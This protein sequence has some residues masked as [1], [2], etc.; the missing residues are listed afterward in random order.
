M[1]VK[2]Q[3]LSILLVVCLL[4]ALGMNAYAADPTS[5]ITVTGAKVNATYT[6]YKIFDA[7]L[8]DD[9]KVAYTLPA[10]ETAESF[11]AN[12]GDGLKWIT[13]ADDGKTVTVTSEFADR[14]TLEKDPDFQNWIKSYAKPEYMVGEAKTATAETGTTLTWDNVPFGYYFVDSS[15]R[16]TAQPPTVMT[17]TSTDGATINEK[18]G[19]PTWDNSDNPP[20]EDDPN[21]GKVIIED[22]VKKTANDANLDEPI[23]FDIGVNTTNYDHANKIHHYIVEDVLAEGMTYITEPVLTIDGN[24]L[25]PTNLFYYTDEAMKTSTTDFTQARAFRAVMKWTN[26]G[27]SDGISL[28]ADGSELHL[29]YQAKLD[30]A[31][32]IDGKV[33]LNDRPNINKAVFMWLIGTGDKPPVTSDDPPVVDPNHK[34]PEKQTKTYTT[35]LIVSKVDGKGDKLTGAE[36]TLEGPN[37]Q[38]VLTMGQNFV[39]DAAGTYWKLKDGTY[40]TTNPAT[41]GVD[42]TLYDRTDVRYKLEDYVIKGANQTDATVKVFVDEDGK[43]TF[44]GLASGSYKLI[45][46]V[47][48]T[49]YN[50]IDD[51]EFTVLFDSTKDKPFYVG[52]GSANVKL[53]ENNA[54]ATTVVNLSGTELPETGGI[55][56]TIFYVLGSLMIVGA[57]VLMITRKRMGREN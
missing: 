2:K 16:D 11:A 50:K 22:G 44:T 1:K 49:G 57:V 32:A 51:L 24:R 43:A 7:Q 34:A 53:G 4:L 42:T 30:S 6:L 8:L 37:G 47:V 48:P 45:E 28:Y 10:G 46:S 3:F 29:S 20:D 27:T 35:Q 21:P 18:N 38:I 19:V 39:E 5:N 41:S 55:G 40:T 54:L 13:I 33:E 52:N 26:D 31:K 9:G 14:E 23:D 15:L 56:T 12:H 17:L 25:V 36:F